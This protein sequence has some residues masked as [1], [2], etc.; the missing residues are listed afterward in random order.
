MQSAV[1]TLGTDERRSARANVILTATIEDGAARI[2]VRVSNLSS[3]GALVI[4]ERLPAAE[5][6]VV[7]RCNGA[8]VQCWVAWCRDD[9]A[10]I[11]FGTP[12]QPDALTQ[13]ESV[14]RIA[15]TKDTRELDFRRPGFRGNQMTDEERKIVEEWNRPEPA[16]DDEGP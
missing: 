2:P 12:V 5:T 14:P 13:R 7:F 1:S 16:S 8:A 10:G 11:Q 6:Q 15:I 9:R 3:H 4:G